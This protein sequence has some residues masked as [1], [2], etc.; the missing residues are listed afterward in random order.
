M[1]VEADSL[2]MHGI[3]RV[4]STS[5]GKIRVVWS[6][7]LISSIAL[8]SFFVIVLVEDYLKYET[9]LVY[10]AIAKPA[11]SFPVVT[12]CNGLRSYSGEN[13]STFTE[14]FDWYSKTNQIFCQYN[15]QLCDV[16]KMT[17]H[18]KPHDK[19][20]LVFNFNETIFQTT[21]M[22]LAGLQIDFFIN[23]SDAT[24]SD[25]S[26]KYN[27][28]TQAAEIF[29]HSS[30]E[31]QFPFVKKIFAKLG[32]LTNIAIKN[33]ITSRKKHPYKSNC[34]ED[35]EKVR[36]Y[37][38]GNYTIT[39]CMLTIFQTKL[40][41]KCGLK[42]EDIKSHFPYEKIGVNVTLNG[43][44]AFEFSKYGISGFDKPTEP[45]KHDCPLPCF[46]E[47]YE[48]KS[49]TEAKYPLEPQLSRFKKQFS[50]KLGAP[51]SNDYIYSSIGRVVIGF[52][53]FHENRYVE[54]PRFTHQKILSEFGGL[55]GVYLGASFISMVELLVYSV[56]SLATCIKKCLKR[57]QMD[58][59]T[60]CS[61]TTSV[62]CGKDDK[63]IS[64]SESV[65]VKNSF[66][67]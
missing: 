11:M 42:V 12:I 56:V 29:I 8:A 34:T 24:Y 35:K 19:S 38:P 39:G 20:C 49:I 13:S 7:L 31:F 41:K 26:D 32:H 6:V 55:I 15:Q 28:R 66:E 25:K 50:S 46:E 17:Y 3:G 40:Y 9:D 21:P 33:V 18:E 58:V 2:T 64:R 5:C 62:A 36:S 4:L 54:T 47:K 53:D 43:T 44:C 27:P 65:I 52:E 59:T 61:Q 48:V 16:A 22:I 23:N 14:G 57:N 63:G 45:T 30:K 51:I 60:E 37:F 10:T 1:E 67:Y